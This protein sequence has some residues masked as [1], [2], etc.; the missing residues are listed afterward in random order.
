[1]KKD[2]LQLEV[3]DFGP[4]ARATVD[5]RP[6]T[7]F[8]GPSNTGKS[9]LAILTYALHRYFGGRGKGLIGN[10]L[11]RFHFGPPHMLPAATVRAIAETA[12]ILRD[13]RTKSPEIMVPL[14]APV[15][16]E[17][18][19]GFES[20][21]DILGNEIRRCFGV[22]EP[23]SLI[24]K[25][26]GRGARI[27]IRRTYDDSTRIA[28]RVSLGNSTVDM[29]TEIPRE[30]MVH[31][32]D[33]TRGYFG[34][35]DAIDQLRRV[36][37]DTADSDHWLAWELLS[38]L[39]NFLLPHIAGP[40]HSPAYYLPADRT[41][42]MHAHNVVVSALIGSAPQAGLR[43]AIQTP[44]L[45]GVLADFLEQLIKIDRTRAPRHRPS[46][47]D[48]GKPIEETVLRGSVRVGRSPTID[49]PHFTYRPKGWKDDLPLNN[50]SSMV[51]ELA[52]VVLY[53]RHLIESNN[54]LIIE[55]PESHLHPGM[56][57]ELTRQLAELVNAGVR[58][59]VTTHSEW[60]LEELANLVKRS[61]LP[62]ARRSDKC[63]LG[64]DQVG[65]WLFEPKLRPKG[66]VVREIS[67][68]E[69]GTFP[70]G[71]DDVATALHNDWADISDE[72]EAG[73]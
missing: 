15:A 48:L 34:F 21:A 69:S 54:V 38:M 10:A 49:Y 70:S 32:E 71:F 62:K 9:Y 45:S 2:T 67:L 46:S 68:D 40:L 41:G 30:F 51:S 28:H 61:E 55:E 73:E 64:P 31:R 65:I 42:V 56:Q 63:A 11:A 59:I 18:R 17:L 66:S 50:A 52:P 47:S 24:R 29:R 7:V 12:I 36:D 57:V 72:I 26:A 6:F 16:A 4:I 43:P 20:R 37:P 5:L 13:D 39:A 8:V 1:M 53:L 44:T 60:V 58:I 27:D 33:A 14:S 19:A 23:R 3:S 22:T 25:S 35:R